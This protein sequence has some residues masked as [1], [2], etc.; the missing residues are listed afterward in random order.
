MPG[1]AAATSAPAP[2]DDA[3]LRVLLVED[4]PA[5]A[6]AAMAEALARE[7]WDVVIADH[8]MPA[9][10]SG[11]ALGVLRRNDDDTPFLIVLG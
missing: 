11:R 3:G 5:D 8:A 7:A 1:P 4:S 2:G 10:S 6:E 9:F